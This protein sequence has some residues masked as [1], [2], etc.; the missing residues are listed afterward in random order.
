[1][2][3]YYDA[4]KRRYPNIPRDR[5]QRRYIPRNDILQKQQQEQEQQLEFQKKMEDTPENFPALGQISTSENSVWGGNKSFAQLASE[6]KQEE[7]K[8][9]IMKRIEEKEQDKTNFAIPKFNNIHRFT[10]E[11]PQQYQEF[12]EVEEVS[13]Q[14]IA[15]NEEDEW[16]TVTSRKQRK[17]KREL[18]I[19]EKFPDPEDQNGNSVWNEDFEKQEYE[20]CWDDK[21]Y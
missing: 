14:D 18:T 15:K 16:V 8:T 1:M 7:D 4:P 9:E 13:K 6:W 20:T 17:P 11:I 5:Q 12:D 10:E 2:S 19:E 3:N 21:R